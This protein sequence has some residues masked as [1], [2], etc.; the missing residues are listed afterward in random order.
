MP[1]PI[2]VRD[3]IDHDMAIKCGNDVAD[4]MKRN[5]Q[6]I[7]TKRGC[8]MA[9]ISGA[10]IAMASMAGAFWAGT[11]IKLDEKALDD[12][13]SQVIRPLAMSAIGQRGHF[14]DMM[15]WISEKEA[16]DGNAA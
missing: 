3:V 7:E 8:A 4:A 12:L 16:A 2:N 10:S 5:Y 9:G 15:K 14:E 6:L 13:W 1:Q 11:G